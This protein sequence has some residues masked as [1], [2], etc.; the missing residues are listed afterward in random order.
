[1]VFGRYRFGNFGFY[2]FVYMYNKEVSSNLILDMYVWKNLNFG[3]LGLYMPDLMRLKKHKNDH[4][5]IKGKV[6][7]I[8]L[9]KVKVTLNTGRYICPHHERTSKLDIP[10]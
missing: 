6:L 10:S 2:F 1:M 4:K 3:F 9:M 8:K 7:S 5:I